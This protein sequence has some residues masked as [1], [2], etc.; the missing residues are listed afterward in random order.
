MYLETILFGFLIIASFALV[1]VMIAGMLMF[2][3]DEKKSKIRARQSR[4]FYKSLK[5]KL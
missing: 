5:S 2:R 1:G 3:S 4:Q